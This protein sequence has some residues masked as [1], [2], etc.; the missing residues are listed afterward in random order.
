[1]S[2]CYA[3]FIDLFSVGHFNLSMQTGSK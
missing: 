2:Y 3:L 1:M